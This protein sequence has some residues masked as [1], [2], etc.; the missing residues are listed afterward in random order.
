M[1]GLLVSLTGRRRRVWFRVPP[2]GGP[3]AAGA[4]ARG[5]YPGFTAEFENL[6]K[7]VQ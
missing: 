1:L 7:E 4:L 6:V 3:V 2:D 5:E